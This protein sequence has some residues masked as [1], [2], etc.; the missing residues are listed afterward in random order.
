MGGVYIASRAHVFLGLN[1]NV[2][3]HDWRLHACTSTRRVSAILQLRVAAVYTRNTWHGGCEGL[4][5]GILELI[6][7]ILELKANVRDLGSVDL[8][9]SM[10]SRSEAVDLVMQH[11]PPF[12]MHH[13][14]RRVQQVCGHVPVHRD[15]DGAKE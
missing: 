7:G 4:I 8:V 1:L 12:F 9:G 3:R 6:V 11:A 10:R 5:V 2:C 14:R 13:V 15:R